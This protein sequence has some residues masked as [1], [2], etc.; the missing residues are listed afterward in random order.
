MFHQNIGYSAVRDLAS[1]VQCL[2]SLWHRL[3]AWPGNFHMQWTQP[4]K[5]RRHSK[6]SSSVSIDHVF[7]WMPVALVPSIV[8]SVKDRYP[9]I[10]NN[11]LKNTGLGAF[12]Y[13]ILQIRN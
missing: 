5:K 7:L 12:K 1:S 13:V 4:K 8:V 2:G 9:L 6:K 3:N 10:G 11:D